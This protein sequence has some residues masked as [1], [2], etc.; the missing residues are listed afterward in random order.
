MKFFA[1]LFLVLSNTSFATSFKV[2]AYTE[3]PFSN[4]IETRFGL[5]ETPVEIKI[6]GGVLSPGYIKSGS[7]VLMD[8][9]QMNIDQAI[10][11]D[12]AYESGSH[13]EIAL[14]SKI[15]ALGSDFYFDF[16]YGF[17]KGQGTLAAEDTLSLVLPTLRARRIP[18]NRGLVGESLEMGLEGEIH[19][20]Q[21][22]FGY[23]FPINPLISLKTEVSLKSAI[24]NSLDVTYGPAALRGLFSDK[25]GREQDELIKALP[26]VPTFILGVNYGLDM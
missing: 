11:F 13:F 19:Y 5:A 12:S 18:L 6:K 17:I 14:G 26:L 23:Q 20:L 16:G 9:D 3:Y 25:L 10:I 1:L 21:G 7:Q 15:P 4:G 22:S 2:G 24:Q 8:L